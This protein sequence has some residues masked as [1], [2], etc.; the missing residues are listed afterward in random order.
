MVVVFYRK[1]PNCIKKEKKSEKVMISPIHLKRKGPAWFSKRKTRKIF[2]HLIPLVKLQFVGFSCSTLACHDTV[3]QLKKVWRLLCEC[4]WEHQHFPPASW[5]SSKSNKENE[6][7]N[8]YPIFG[9][10]RRQVYSPDS[11]ICKR[12]PNAMELVGE[13]EKC[14][15]NTLTG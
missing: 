1:Y 7:K 10:I 3:R 5:K 4:S 11:K 13:S 14:K 9:E 15:R 6:K 12:T 8:A 2:K